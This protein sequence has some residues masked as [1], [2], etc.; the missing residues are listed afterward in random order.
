MSHNNYVNHLKI[1]SNQ[2]FLMLSNFE[3]DIKSI[4]VPKGYVVRLYNKEDYMGEKIVL[5]ES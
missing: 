3:H 5:K 4:Y 2:L 1:L